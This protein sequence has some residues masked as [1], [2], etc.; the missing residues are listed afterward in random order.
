MRHNAVESG[1]K[2]E[3]RTSGTLFSCGDVQI[4]VVPDS[5][6]MEVTCTGLPVNCGKRARELLREDDAGVPEDS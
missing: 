1:C 5:K 4:W 2:L 3:E 6:G